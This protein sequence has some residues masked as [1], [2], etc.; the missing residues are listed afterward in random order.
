MTDAVSHFSLRKEAPH[1]RLWAALATSASLHLCVA[2]VLL[3]EAPRRPGFEQVT[4]AISARLAVDEATVEPPV[5]MLQLPKKAPAPQ[6]LGQGEAARPPRPTPELAHYYSAT[7]LD[8]FPQPLAPLDLSRLEKAAKRAAGIRA[9]LK[10]DE[11]GL[12]NDVEIA[13][14]DRR[15]GEAV[16]AALVATPFAPALK[17]GRPVRSRI[18]LDVRFASY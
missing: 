16:R 6:Q 15:T 14:A 10:I 12:V 1:G 5:P 18:V 11:L 2:G 17:D 9:V 4:P 7:E 13:G 8:V 3:P